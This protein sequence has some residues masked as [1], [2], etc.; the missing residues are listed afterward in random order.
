LEL[1][2]SVEWVDVH[3]AGGI[4]LGRGRTIRFDRNRI[5]AV[6][7]KIVRGLFFKH[8]ERRLASNYV[9]DEF[10]YNPP[11]EKPLLEALL[12]VPLCKI[13]DG[14]VLSYRYYL[15]DPGGSESH[16]FLMFYNDTS[17]FR[18]QTLPA[19]GTSAQT[20]ATVRRRRG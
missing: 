14:S 10:F 17:L 7:D 15:P 11:I 9:V 12:E 1:L 18:T 6:I 16:W 2:E 5:Q 19:S 20:T 13:G 8:T 3:S 4:Y